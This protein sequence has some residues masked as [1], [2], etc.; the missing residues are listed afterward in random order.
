M[1]DFTT[2]LGLYINICITYKHMYTKDL[3][4]HPSENLCVYS[5]INK[6]FP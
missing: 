6:V 2:H 4:K 1:Y 5:I 3:A